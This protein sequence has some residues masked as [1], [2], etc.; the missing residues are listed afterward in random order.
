MEINY[1]ELKKVKTNVGEYPNSS[2]L[3]VTKN[4]PQSLIK[5]L[6]ENGHFLFGENRVQEAKE[7]FSSL[8]ENNIELHLIGPL[9]TNKVKLALSIFN[10][11]QSIDRPKLVKEISKQ[12]DSSD[13]IKTKNYYIQVNIGEESQKA[14]TSI[15]E[16]RDLYQYA[17]SENLEI[18]GLMCI[19]PFEVKPDS[20]FKKMIELRDDIDPKL[21]LSMGMSNDYEVALSYHS[22]LVRVGSRIFK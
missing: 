17:I 5:L 4:R 18:S 15:N 12:I 21:K 20:Y 7:K 16:T 11:I 1:D 6:I 13:K 14:G 9:Q 3:L 22:D 19:P 10:T 2:L 8:D